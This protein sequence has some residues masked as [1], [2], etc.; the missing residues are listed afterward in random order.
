MYT[1]QPIRTIRRPTVI[2]RVDVRVARRVRLNVSGYQTDGSGVP[3]RVEQR[4]TGDRVLVRIF[5]EWDIDAICP[6]AILPYDDTVVLDGSF[7][8]G[9]Y[10]VDV[11][12]HV[13]QMTVARKQG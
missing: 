12:G 3:V 7:P 10:T 2:E 4:R 11:N 8:K 13:V 5:R 6:A 9:T 1:H